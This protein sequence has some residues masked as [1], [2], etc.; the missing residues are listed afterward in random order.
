MTE[1]ATLKSLNGRRFSARALMHAT[2]I[3]Q[4]TLTNYHTKYGLDEALCSESAG[5]GRRRAYCYVDVL[6]T[7]LVP[8]LARL[9]GSVSW[10]VQAVGDLLF[11][12]HEME[13]VVAA[14]TRRGGANWKDV[15]ADTSVDSELAAMRQYYKQVVCKNIEAAP[16]LY[17][18]R[19]DRRPV[20]LYASLLD[21][22]HAGAINWAQWGDPDFIDPTFPGGIVWNATLH[23]I[24]LDHRLLE[25][26]NKDA[27]S[28]DGG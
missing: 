3:N 5:Q 26:V 20:L 14:S 21:M 24:S 8:P 17:R 12:E 18:C 2:R 9:S 28:R 10:A 6:S 27:A 1:F 4:N 19:N 25:F 22:R 15:L 11:A 13:A 23:L 7:G 16:L